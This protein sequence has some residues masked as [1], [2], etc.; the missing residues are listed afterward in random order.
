MKKKKTF[1]M[2]KMNERVNLF[3]HFYT[4]PNYDNIYD[5]VS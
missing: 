3:N 4:N 1:D 5:E 2:L